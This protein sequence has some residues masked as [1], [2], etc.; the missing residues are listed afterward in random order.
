MKNMMRIFVAI[1]II[2]VPLTVF[3]TAEAAGTEPLVSVELRNYLG[4]KSSITI[5]PSALYRLKDENVTL[6]AN[7]DYEVKIA[8]TNVVLYQEGEK[9]GEFSSFEVTPS[10]YDAKLTINSMSYLGDM[11]FTNESNKYVRPIN[12]LP[13]EDYIKGVVGK[14]LYW[15]FKTDT[16]KAQAI[17]A[18]TYVLSLKKSVINDTTNFQVYGGDYWDERIGKAVE[19]TFGQ[20]LTYKGSIINSVYS[21]SNGGIIQSNTNVWGTPV[22]TY[23]QVKDDPYDPQRVWTKTVRKKQID[24]SDKDLKKPEEWWS[25]TKEA[26]AEMANRIKDKMTAGELKGK[27]I[28]ITSISKINFYAPDSAK[29]VTKGDI[30]VK[31]IVKNEF[32]KNGNIEEKQWDLIGSSAGTINYLITEGGIGSKYVTDINDDGTSIIIKGKGF[33]H[34][35]GMSQFGADAMATGDKNYQEILAF[36]YPTTLLTSA[37]DTAYPRVY[38]VLPN[39]PEVNDITSEDSKVTGK[40]APG[41]I[42]YVK[43]GS[44]LL[45][46]STV[47]RQGTYSVSI[48]PQAAKTK[49]GVLIKDSVGYSAY[50]YKTVVQKV[51]KP[52]APTINKI[53]DQDISVSGTAEANSIV[54]VKKG[55]TVLGRGVATKKGTY[56]IEIAS[57]SANTKLGVTVKNSAGYSGYTYMTVSKTFQ[58]PAAPVIDIVTDQDTN[59]TGTAEANSIVYVKKGSTVLGR[60]VATK[61]GTYSIGIAPQPAN[62]KIGVTLKNSSGYSAYTYSTVVAKYKVPNAPTVSDITDEA[63]VVAGTTEAGSRVYVKAGTNVI[64]IGTANSKGAF[65]I[66]IPK[67]AVSTKI[68]V[69]AKGKGGYSPYTYKTVVSSSPSA[70]SVNRVFSL[71]KTVSGTTEPKSVV[72]I[73]K[74]SELIGRGVADS[75]GSFN[76]AIT[77]QAAKTKISII[78]KNPNGKYSPYRIVTVG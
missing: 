21:S 26:D 11:K 22:N 72:Y 30:S 52:E 73:K 49:V 47:S 69:T 28:K 57:Q 31:Y 19:D 43:K 35:I 23:S 27:D 76:I 67:E 60:G 12:T 8:G 56:S 75:K 51:T 7:K 70:P 50:T 59:V 55:S 64:G 68:G 61:Q 34:G 13:M 46:R 32:D 16:F 6:Q 63:K 41:S 42:V 29:R 40:A 25:K 44:T 2:L 18:R 39:A 62:T 48:H 45:G 58:K 66:S 54:Y 37:Y 65:S 20:V 10:T 1:A 15:S 3:S 71:A 17:A 74:G 4:N 9:L 33:G 36:Y 14:E 53:Y 5:H 38:K 77:P 78:I 24:L